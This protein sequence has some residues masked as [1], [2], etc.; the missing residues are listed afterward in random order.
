MQSTH[1]PSAVQKLFCALP[2]SIDGVFVSSP[3]NIYYLCGFDY[4][5]GYLLLSRAGCILFTD[6]RYEEAARKSVTDEFCVELITALRAKQLS[7]AAHRLGITTLGYEDRTLSCA[8]Y[9]Y[10][11]KESAELNWT[12]L[13]ELLLELRSKKSEAEIDCIRKAQRIAEAALS[14]TL[15]L[16]CPGMTEIEVAAELEYQMRKRG[17]QGNAFDTIAI[18]GSATSLPHGTPQNRPLQQGFLT[19][20]FGARYGG[21][22]S[23]MTRTVYLGTPTQ[24]QRAVYE[25]VLTAQLAALSKIQCGADCGAVHATAAA[26][27]DGAGYRGCFGHGLGHGVGLQIHEQPRLSPSGTGVKL[28]AGHVVTVEPGIYLAGKYGVRIEDMVAVF[29]DHVENLTVFSK[30]FTQIEGF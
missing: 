3:E 2:E 4:E 18:S 9:H 25:C 28:Q 13:G 5:D 12:P 10:F 7:E 8:K 23:D 22:C 21:Y 6:F 20:D 11:Q 16:L 26:I 24:Q 17:A 1:S 19:M 14:A 30:E 29:D 27:I 15:P